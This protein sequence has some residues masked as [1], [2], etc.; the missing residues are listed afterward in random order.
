MDQVHSHRKFPNT[1]ILIRGKCTDQ[2]CLKYIAV[3]KQE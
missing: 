1:E 3:L 2:S